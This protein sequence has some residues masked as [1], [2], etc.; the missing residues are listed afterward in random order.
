MVN[1]NFPAVKNSFDFYIEDL[2]YDDII[3]LDA[4]FELWQRHWRAHSH[5]HVTNVVDVLKILGPQHIFFP[6]IVQL[7]E[8]YATLPVSVVRVERSF[9]TL[10][11][12]RTFLR[13][14]TGD[15][16][17]SSLAILSIHKSIIG[18]LNPEKVVPSTVRRV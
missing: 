6:N 8:L 18:Q 1:L 7:L 3:V 2:P 16:R 14:K 15:E 17:S 5:N 11:L 9:S 10:K 13:N 4:E 12:I